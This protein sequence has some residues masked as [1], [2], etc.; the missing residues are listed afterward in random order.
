LTT[1]T[2]LA[3]TRTRIAPLGD[4]TFNVFHHEIRILTHDEDSNDAPISINGKAFYD[5]STNQRF[6]ARGVALSAAGTSLRVDDLLSDDNLDLMNSTIIPKLSY[7][8]V[9]MIRVYQV[10]PSNSH[11]KVMHTLA[12]NGIYDSWMNFRPTTTPCA[13]RLATKWNFLASRRPI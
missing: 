9:N 1:S 11:V 12:R 10:S 13:S 8:N 7:L 3:F 4:N 2:I 5:A 6:M